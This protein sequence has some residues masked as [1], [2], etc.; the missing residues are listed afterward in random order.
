MIIRFDSL[1]FEYN[2]AGE[3]TSNLT[4]IKLFTTVWLI[5]LEGIMESYP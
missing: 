4:K 5:L 3:E 2:L 1:K